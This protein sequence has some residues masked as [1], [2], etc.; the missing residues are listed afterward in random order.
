MGCSSSTATRSAASA[1]AKTFPRDCK[2]SKIYTF[3]SA[4]A[5]QNEDRERGRSAHEED[6]YDRQHRRRSRLLELRTT[7]GPDQV[8]IRELYPPKPT[9]CD[10]Q[11]RAMVRIARA[12]LANSLA[13]DHPATADMLA[14]LPPR[15][16]RG[17]PVQPARVDAPSI[18]L[19]AMQLGN[20]YLFVQGPPGSGKSTYA[21]E[22]IA[23]LLAAG[24]RVAVTSTTH[25]A[26]HNLLHKVEDC[27]AARGSRFG[28]RYKHAKQ[29]ES[30]EYRSKLDDP[31]IASNGKNE[32]FDSD[33]YQLAAGTAWL[34]ARKSSP[35]SSIT[36]SST[37]PGRSRL[38]TH[39]PSRS[40]RA[41][42]CCSATRR[43]WHRSAKAPSLCTGDSVLQHLLGERD[44][45][46][47][48][49]DIPRL[50]YR[51]QPEICGFVSAMT[52]DGRSCTRRRP[53]A[54][55]GWTQRVASWPGSTICRSSTPPKRREFGRRGRRDPAPDRRT[56]SIRARII[57]VTPYNA[58]RRAI[59]Q[60]LADAGIPVRV[61]TV[62]K[63]QGQQAAVVF[64]SMATSSGE[65]LPR[66]LEFLFE[67]NRF[68]VAISR[69]QAVSVLVCSPRLLDISCRTP[70]EMA[71]VNLVCAF[72]ERA[73]QGL[74][75]NALND[76]RDARAGAGAVEF[77][78]HRRRA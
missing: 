48:P 22:V 62:H 14:K 72:V 29:N 65:E 23:D 12:F 67:R 64:Y 17:G 37:R 13:A 71:L 36:S 60:R 66:S 26:I 40:A 15:L 51:M 50:S 78:S 27:V 49:R 6:L 32:P 39:S 9:P 5:T 76:E 30:S 73:H 61:G 21:S 70:D 33:D 74:S 43:N 45:R 58:Q 35:A 68:N 4:A 2:R 28:G 69:A 54:A 18:S 55:T 57:V 31:M 16:S 1:C 8:R 38:P 7:A 41:T 34:L 10:P 24:K 52:Y 47:R 63:F 20:S 53:R 19:T 44:G 77:E 75:G 25:A 11:R 59:A 42:S 3:G 56:L 46:A